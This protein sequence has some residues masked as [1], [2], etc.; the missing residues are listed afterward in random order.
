MKGWC[1]NCLILSRYGIYDRLLIQLKTR[2]FTHYPDNKNR[3]DYNNRL[4]LLNRF[5]ITKLNDRYPKQ[6][7]SSKIWFLCNILYHDSF[8]AHLLLVTQPET[9]RPLEI[10]R[11]NCKDDIKVDLTEDL[12]DADWVRLMMNWASE[13]RVKYLWVTW[14]SGKFLACNWANDGFGR[15]AVFKWS[16]SSLFCFF[17]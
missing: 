4:P 17:V 11:S 5:V 8:G 10:T 6:K 9:E 15:P 14:K 16:F 2:F 1:S 7:M 3:L 12:N 13:N